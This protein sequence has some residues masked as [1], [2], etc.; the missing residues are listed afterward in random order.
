MVI[1]QFSKQN[2]KKLLIRVKKM[3]WLRYEHIAQ[4]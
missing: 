3:P 1:V 4:Q 2:E